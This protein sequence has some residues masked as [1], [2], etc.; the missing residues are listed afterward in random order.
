MARMSPGAGLAYNHKITFGVVSAFTFLF[1]VSYFISLG[2][3][4]G[5]EPT[6]KSVEG[7]FAEFEMKFQGNDG[8]FASDVKYYSKGYQYD[9]MFT[10]N[11]V[12]LNLYSTQ[13]SPPGSSKST[14]S[15]TRLS[16]ISLEFIG[17][18]KSPRLKG[19]SQFAPTKVASAGSIGNQQLAAS[20]TEVKYSNIY[21]GVD[22]YFSGKQ[23]QLFYEFILSEVADVNNITMKVHGLEGMGQFEIDMH[24]NIDVNCHGKQMQI[25]KPEVF[26]VVNQQKVPVNG[27]F[28]VTPDNEIRFKVANDVKLS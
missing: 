12:L 2:F 5:P 22:V 23:K 16:Q 4:N 7:F 21:P 27:Y 3:K 20:F 18:E 11:E 19:L 25:K 1:V 17:A 6:V 14:N 28:I 13:I 10:S 8:N 15:K 24:G 26:R 9:L